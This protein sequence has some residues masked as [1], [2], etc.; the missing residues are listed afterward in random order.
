[1]YEQPKTG[2]VFTIVDPNLQLNVLDAVQRE[3]ASL[4]EHGLNAPAPEGAIG[5]TNALTAIPAI[6]VS[7]SEALASTD[8]G[9]QPSTPQEPQTN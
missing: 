5:G 2:D 4:L 6:E 1:V 9:Y 8:A 3:V 7:A